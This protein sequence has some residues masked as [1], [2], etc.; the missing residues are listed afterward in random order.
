MNNKRISHHSDGK[1]I[2][3]ERSGNQHRQVRQDKELR[4]LHFGDHDIQAVIDLAQPHQL[5]LP[6][7]FGMLSALLY[8]PEPI[9]CLNLGVGG[10]SFERFFAHRL[11]RLRVTSLESDV[12]VIRLARDYFMLPPQQPVIVDD[13]SHFLVRHQGSYD[14]IFC[15]IH[16]GDNH[17]ECLS[18]SQFHAAAFGCLNQDGVYAINLLPHNYSHLV[19]VLMRLRDSFSDVLVLDIP[20]RRNLI[21]F[22]LK[23]PPPERNILTQRLSMLTKQFHMP[24]QQLRIP[25]TALPPR[26][27]H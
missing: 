1:L 2:H 12:N 14:L 19:T 22:A 24:A 17:P 8:Q 11:P 23:Q 26:E 25:K 27:P 15:D 7:S 6:Y 13:A 5:I 10:G 20:E 9:T 3:Q 4:W 16:Q 21:L 18:D